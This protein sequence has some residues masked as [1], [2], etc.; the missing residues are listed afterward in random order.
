[1]KRGSLKK[2]I[3]IAMADEHPFDEIRIEIAPL[4]IELYQSFGFE[5]FF[6][7]GRKQGR[8]I[9]N[10]RRG[11]EE[12]RWNRWYLLLRIWDKIFLRWYSYYQPFLRISGNR[13]DVNVP[14]DLRHLSVKILSAL[15][16]LHQ[17]DFDLVVR[18]TASSI[19]NPLMLEESLPK[20]S[21]F[22]KPLYAGRKISQA[23]GFNFVSG[24]FTILNSE[25]MRLLRDSRRKI[26]FS[27]IDDVAFG[28]IF[29]DYKVPILDIHSVNISKLEDLDETKDFS[30]MSH[31]RC[32]TGIKQRNDIEVMRKLLVL[33]KEDLHNRN[34]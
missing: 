32:R 9:R 24:C 3:L 12:M 27:L 28:R 8:F 15:N 11:V 21:D 31:F 10:I 4:L 30:S 1:M 7:Y 23:D 6:V 34:I 2:A 14:E 22:A 29:R 33:I 25:S 16:F 13:V 18:T 26:D 5:T 20:K 17:S 19:I